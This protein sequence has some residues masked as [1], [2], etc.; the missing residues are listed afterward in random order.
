[1]TAV[2]WLG[3]PLAGLFLCFSIWAPPAWAAQTGEP[4]DLEAVES[5]C[6]LCDEDHGYPVRRLHEAD[7]DSI[8]RALWSHN[9]HVFLRADS[10]FEAGFFGSPDQEEARK[11]ARDYFQLRAKNALDY[12]LEMSLQPKTVFISDETAMRRPFGEF[13][14][15]TAVYPL[16]LLKRGVVGPGGFCMEYTIPRKYK[17]TVLSG[18]LPVKLEDDWVET[19]EGE[20]LHVLALEHRSSI[21][22]KIKLLYEDH[23]CGRVRR[24]TVNDRGDT[25]DLMII[26]DLRGLYA[27]K[28]GV[29]RM[30]A[31]VY[32]KSLVEGDEVPAAPRMGSYVYFPKIHI[33][34]PI[35]LPNL[36]LDDLRIFSIPQPIIH[37]ASFVQWQDRSP[38]WIELMPAIGVSPWEPKGPIPEIVLQRFPDL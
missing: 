21:H 10:L 24:E 16:R 32:W 27:Q 33:D 25:L 12:L 34:L 23:F 4:P 35:F 28:A 30:E 19:H 13:Y 1:M 22:S 37:I 26:E 36:G 20:R 8:G 5:A 6:R 17:D 7:V 14:S 38:R 9:H 29:H 3:R 18:G 2:R 15:S 31:I 11:K